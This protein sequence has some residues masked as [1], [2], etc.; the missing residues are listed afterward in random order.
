M[1]LRSLPVQ[2]RNEA[3]LV[4]P[5]EYLGAAMAM[6]LDDAPTPDFPPKDGPQ[7]Q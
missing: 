5:G 3:M 2:Y 4:M 6:W 7:P 1:P